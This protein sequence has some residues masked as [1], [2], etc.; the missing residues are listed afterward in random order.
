MAH[1]SQ[2]AGSGLGGVLAHPAPT[3]ARVR[4]WPAAPGGGAAA[5]GGAV[6]PQLVRSPTLAERDLVSEL[7]GQWRA[8]G[9][10]DKPAPVMRRVAA[11]AKPVAVA[12]DAMVGRSVREM[13]DA[14]RDAAW[15]SPALVTTFVVVVL[16]DMPGAAAAVRAVATMPGIDHATLVAPGSTYDVFEVF[17]TTPCPLYRTVT[18][19]GLLPCVPT[20]G[21]GN[22]FSAVSPIAVGEFAAG[23]L[24]LGPGAFFSASL[25][26]LSAAREHEGLLSPAPLQPP[27][28]GAAAAA[29]AAATVAAAPPVDLLVTALGRGA[30]QPLVASYDPGV[31][32]SLGL[33]KALD[34]TTDIPG[35]LRA[36][37][38]PS[39]GTKTQVLV[40]YV[41]E[42]GT[43]LGVIGLCAIYD[44]N[45]E[46]RLG[47]FSFQRLGPLARV[48]WITDASLMMSRQ[49]GAAP[50]PAKSAEVF[51]RGGA[52]QWAAPIFASLF[53]VH[54]FLLR[55]RAAVT[56]RFDP[57]EPGADVAIADALEVCA[58][59]L[60]EH[61]SALLD[62]REGCEAARYSL[63]RMGHEL[64]G[65]LASALESIATC[66]ALSLDDAATV[67]RCA[68][69]LSEWGAG[70]G[71]G[72]I[73]EYASGPELQGARG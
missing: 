42:A 22:A 27:P 56:S 59:V 51:P 17:C 69:R 57:D 46:E 6:A 49:P 3:T 26:G 34:D 19:G 16:I 39:N 32:E 13:I 44:N 14:L 28:P 30:A 67:A 18:Q 37:L 20:A 65:E 52:G 15:L 71:T 8:L 62:L 25:T 45:S 40:C 2:A 43:D 47:H 48:P 60:P 70:D 41:L 12:V 11:A 7:L 36:P 38:V 55:G 31:L 9:A 1:V 54:C 50:A 10:N 58:S 23:E 64:R 4:L 61:D 72:I 5:A 24:D 63:A 29:A 66:E 73:L 21:G 33:L 53:T 68:A 35:A